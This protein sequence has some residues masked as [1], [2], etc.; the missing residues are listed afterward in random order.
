MSSGRDGKKGRS[1]RRAANADS[2]ARDSEAA[3]YGKDEITHTFDLPL[4]RK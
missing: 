4:Q 2:R 1:D 3:R